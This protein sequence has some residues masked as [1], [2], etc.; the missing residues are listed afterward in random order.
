[1]GFESEN[2]QKDSAVVRIKAL[3]QQVLAGGNVDSEVSVLE[4]IINKLQNNQLGPEDAIN[5]AETL[6]SKRQDY[7]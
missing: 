7:H 4:S 1:M 3:E 6:V 2:F 5:Q